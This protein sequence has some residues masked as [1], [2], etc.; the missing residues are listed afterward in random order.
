MIFYHFADID[1]EGFRNFTRFEELTGLDFIPYGMGEEEIIKYQ[2]VASPL[3]PEDR[4]NL[5]KMLKLSYYNKFY[6]VINFMLANNLKLEL[7]FFEL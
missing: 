7:E 4:K 5:E 1:P 6:K 3:L 2:S